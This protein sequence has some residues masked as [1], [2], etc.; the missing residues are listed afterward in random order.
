[1]KSLEAAL[2]IAPKSEK[3]EKCTFYKSKKR[4][5]GKM[6]E[7][8]TWTRGVESQGTSEATTSKSSGTADK[9]SGT[10]FD[11]LVTEKECLEF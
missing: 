8:L 3:I 11:S 2:V 10:V 7:R 4:N 1:M 5:R 9:S 6:A